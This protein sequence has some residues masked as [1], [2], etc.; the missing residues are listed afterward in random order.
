MK[1]KL[2]LKILK[3]KGNVFF[4]FFLFFTYLL[5]LG[6]ILGTGIFSILTY[7]SKYYAGPSS[8]LSFLIAAV[9]SCLGGK[10]I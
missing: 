6:P 9:A 5:A 10:F 4:I 7:A 3:L 1:Q 8:L 2:I